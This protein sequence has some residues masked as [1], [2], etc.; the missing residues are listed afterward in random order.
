MYND[1][2]QKN[3]AEKDYV[4]AR[5]FVDNKFI[6]ESADLIR[7]LEDTFGK[8][9]EVSE[10]FGSQVNTAIDEIEKTLAVRDELV[11][12]LKKNL[13]AQKGG[14][15]RIGELRKTMRHTNDKLILCSA[16]IDNYKKYLYFLNGNTDSLPKSTV[17]FL[18]R[19]KHEE[20][21]EP[22]KF[23]AKL[24]FAEEA[25]A[26]KAHIENKDKNKGDL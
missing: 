15:E 5:Q 18:A 26:L 1:F 24:D 13:E 19:E 21:L 25:L 12:E 4:L 20:L 3:V 16:H 6:N 17:D 10:I 14:G 11:E 23:K 8:N 9:T 22:V 2:L 7:I